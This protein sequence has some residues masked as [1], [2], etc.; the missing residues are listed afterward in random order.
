M[1][2]TFS[3]LGVHESPGMCA[4]VGRYG[5]ELHPPGAGTQADAGKFIEVW[6]RQPDGSWLISDDIFNSDLPAPPA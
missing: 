4:A 1:S 6:S 2:P 3:L 5:K